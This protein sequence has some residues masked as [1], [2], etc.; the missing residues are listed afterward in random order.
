MSKYKTEWKPNKHNPKFWNE[1]LKDRVIRRLRWK[2]STLHSFVLD[3]G[4]TVYIVGTSKP[5]LGIKD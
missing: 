5:T 2:G 4:E 1:V 3:S